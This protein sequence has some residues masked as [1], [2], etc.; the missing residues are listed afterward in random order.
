MRTYQKTKTWDSLEDLTDR[1][2][3]AF[4]D[5]V[6]RETPGD[7]DT[8][9]DLEDSKTQIRAMS[10]AFMDNVPQTIDEVLSIEEELHGS[11]TVGKNQIPIWGFTD[12][13][14]TCPTTGSVQ[15]RD[16]KTS[17]K[18]VNPETQANSLQWDFYGTLANQNGYETTEI[19]IDT[20]RYLK[21]KG[22]VHDYQVIQRGPEHTLR[23]A[24][25]LER[26]VYMFDAEAFVPNPQSWSCHPNR[27]EYWEDCAF[28]A[29]DVE[30]TRD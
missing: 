11:I 14:T 27:C 5:E 7:L 2:L 22:P 24:R 15:V 10:Q 12:A 4:E 30:V 13:I 18:K 8:D 3:A 23:L 28:R 9:P 16:W 29:P 17:S 21:T 1:T 26:V 6:N 20:L 19:R 25:M